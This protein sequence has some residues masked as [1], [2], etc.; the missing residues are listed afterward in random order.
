MS[1]PARER[2]QVRAALSI[3]AGCTVATGLYAVVRV[4]QS[5]VLTE[6]DPALVLWSEHAGFFWRALTV[7]YLGGMAAFLTWLASARSAARVAALLVRALP[8]AAALL[9]AQALLVP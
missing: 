1:P 6:P 4:V 2:W 9:A 3:V 8:V 5:L 7:G